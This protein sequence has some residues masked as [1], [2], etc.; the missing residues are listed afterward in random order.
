MKKL[1]SAKSSE[2][3]DSVREQENQNRVRI[4]TIHA[5]K[6]LE[7]PVVFLADTY[8]DNSHKDAYSCFID[9]PTDADK[10]QAF[11]LLPKKDQTPECLKKRLSAAEDKLRREDYHLLY[12]AI[13]RAINMLFISGSKTRDLKN[14]WYQLIADA[15]G[16]TAIK[17]HVFDKAVEDVQTSDIKITAKPLPAL[18]R[19]KNKGFISPSKGDDKFYEYSSDNNQEQAL[20]RG[21]VIHHMLYCLN[22]NQML[23]YPPNL[24]ITNLDQ[25]ILEAWQN[26]VKNL[27]N[28]PDLRQWFDKDHY[29]QAFNEVSILVET[30]DAYVNGIIDRLVLNDDTAFIIDYKTHTV[31]DNDELKNIAQ[32]YQ[33]QMQWY[34]RSV[35]KLYPDKQCKSIIIFT[36]TQSWFEV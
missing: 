28:Q 35:A 4:M 9:W 12:V 5:A 23:S 1:K 16:D 34:K 17:T 31:T 24:G 8:A 15:V 25:G 11:Y 30:D 21:Q 33:S 10:V 2:K 29:Q 18:N 22:E 6:G 19:I 13:T 27:I 26:E 20:L 7:A 3:P 14:T 32:H 36:Y